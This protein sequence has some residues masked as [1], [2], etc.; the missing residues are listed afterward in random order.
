MSFKKQ[1]VLDLVSFVQG[2][3]HEQY[4]SVKETSLGSARFWATKYLFASKDG[5]AQLFSSTNLQRKDG[6]TSRSRLG[7]SWKAA[8]T[9]S[10]VD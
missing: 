10:K 5:F 4:E 8:Y 9:L 3:K 7:W 6:K 2:N 1:C